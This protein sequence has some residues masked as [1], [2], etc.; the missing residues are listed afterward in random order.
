MVDVGVVTVLDVVV[1]DVVVVVVVLPGQTEKAALGAYIEYS[2]T[3]GLASSLR[4]MLESP[5]QR[6]R[7]AS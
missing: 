6:L 4:E 7:V 2:P 3:R 1:L 5:L